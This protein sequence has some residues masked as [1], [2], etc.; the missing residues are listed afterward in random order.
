MHEDVTDNATDN[1]TDGAIDNATDNATD[2]AIDKA[3]YSLKQQTTQK[4]TQQYTIKILIYDAK[5]YNMVLQTT[6]HNNT[7]QY[8]AV[9]YRKTEHNIIRYNL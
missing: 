1:R 9:Q 4:I 5:Q 3:I 8:S 6:K 2:N 7:L